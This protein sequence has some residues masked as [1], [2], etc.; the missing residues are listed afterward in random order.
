M[1]P[2]KQPLGFAARVAWR[3]ARALCGVCGMAL[4]VLLMHPCHM[5]RR[6]GGARD[7]GRRQVANGAPKR[8]F[9]MPLAPIIGEWVLANCGSSGSPSMLPA[10]ITKSLTD[11][12]TIAFLAGVAAG[13]LGLMLL[14]SR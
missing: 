12:T 2:S 7:F 3:G 11:R 6:L 5:L 4:R 9:V 13:A 14:R 1:R 10:A 8:V